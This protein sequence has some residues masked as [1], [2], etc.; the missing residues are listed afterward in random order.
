MKKGIIYQITFAGS[1][2]IYIGS[3]IRA[4]RQR[5]SEHLHLLRHGKHHSKYLQNAFNKHG[6]ENFAFAVI[7]TV[8]ANLMLAREQFHIWRQGKNSM[9]S[10]PVADSTL[11]ATLANT[12]RKQDEAERLRRRESQLLAI[13]RG[14][15]KS[16][17][18]T[19]EERTAHSIRLTGR[20]MPPV[21]DVTRKKISLANKGRK[22]PVTAIKNSVAT[23]Q[24]F[25]A[26]ELPQWLEMRSSG[27]SYREIEA[28]TGRSRDVIARECK[29][30]EKH[31]IKTRAFSKT[32]GQIIST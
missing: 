29:R 23:R 20:K 26:K 17:V 6:E 5:R 25:I 31:A 15:R 28:V 30:A 24:A 27:M 32:E 16:R 10:A 19:D 1:T 18:W 7:E 4:S 14:T 9:N 3:T 2:G 22:T 21:A 13:K 12:G 11:C 8:D